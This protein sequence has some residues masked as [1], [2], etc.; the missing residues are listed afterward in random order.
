VSDDHI[1]DVL[2]AA[3]SALD[4]ADSQVRGMAVWCLGQAGHAERLSDQP[5]LLADEGPV[6]IFEDGFLRRTTVSRLAKHAI[7]G[8]SAEA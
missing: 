3:T 1:S 2:P 8:G 5:H 6:D 7:H 4:D